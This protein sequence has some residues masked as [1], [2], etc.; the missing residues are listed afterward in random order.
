MSEVE[1]LPEADCQDGLPHPRHAPRLIGHE[2]A[3]AAFC[4]ALA[5]DRMHH[6]WLITG[7][8]GIGKATFAWKAAEH[9]LSTPNDQ[10][11]ALFDVPPAPAG[12]SNDPEGP[13]ARRLRALSEPRVMVLRRGWNEKSKKLSAEITVDEVRRLNQF[14]GLSAVDGGRRVVIVD[15][16]DEMNRNAA[17]A[18]L[19]L[20]E[21]PPADAV[22]LL[23]AHQPAKLLPTIRSRCRSLRLNPLDPQEMAEALHSIEIAVDDPAALVELANGSVGV[24]AQMI[25]GGG[26]ALYAGLLALFDG[27]P[28]LDRAKAITLSEQVTGKAGEVQFDLTL[29]LLDRLL[30]RLARVGVTGVLPPEI[31]AGE[32]AVL[33]RLAP[34]AAEGRAWADL[35]DRLSAKARQG[36]AVNLDP[37]ALILDMVISI[38]KAAPRVMA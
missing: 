20:L 21:E 29:A 10:G 37:A 33:S 5:S 3:V 23:V 24:A 8:K 22:L 26:L 9:L 14:F 16:V 30:A 15:A 25:E 17:N 35:A 36:R 12:F 4:T 32:G 7:P 13:V 19:K 6:A 38:E 31:V 1:T 18:L 27:L 28:R 34:H 2:A 11:A